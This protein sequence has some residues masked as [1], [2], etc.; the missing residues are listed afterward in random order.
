MAKRGQFK[1]GAK[2]RSVQQRRY[3]STPQA[4]SDRAQRNKARR[5]AIR[6]GRVKKGSKSDV[7]HVGGKPG[8]LGNKT[9]VISRSKNRALGGRK[10]GRK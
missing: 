8:R 4:K 10:G 6:T 7:H 5:K 3:N 9:R 1:S 2:K